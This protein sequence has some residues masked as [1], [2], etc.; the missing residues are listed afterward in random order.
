MSMRLRAPVSVRLPGSRRT[1]GQRA[2]PGLGWAGPSGGCVLLAGWAQ[3]YLG[4]TLVI[5]FFH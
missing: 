5:L 3:S 4:W 1:T 2:L